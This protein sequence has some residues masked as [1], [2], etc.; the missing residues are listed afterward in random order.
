MNAGKSLEKLGL[1]YYLETKTVIMVE[2]PSV[3][4]N[5]EEPASLMLNKFFYDYHCVFY[6]KGIKTVPLRR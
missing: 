5:T 4:K 1:S 2:E 6:I 3:T